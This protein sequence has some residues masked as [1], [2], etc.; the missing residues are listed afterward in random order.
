MSDEL[1]GCADDTS[2]LGRAVAAS[3]LRMA[4]V[5]RLVREP[6]EYAAIAMIMAA[7]LSGIHERPRPERRP[8]TSGLPKSKKEAR[9]ARNAAQKA[10]RKITRQR[11]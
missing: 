10:A 11:S 4:D 6:I 8:W 7:A 5:P 1:T 3:G 9:R 2:P